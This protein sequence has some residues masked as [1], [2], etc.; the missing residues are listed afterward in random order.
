MRPRCREGRK[1]SGCPNV[2]RRE[3]L[4]RLDR[5]PELHALLGLVGMAA[6][7]LAQT[8]HAVAQRVA[9]HAEALRRIA[10]AAA[11]LE[12]RRQRLDEPAVLRSR[13]ED[14]VDERLEGCVGEREKEL[15]RS[16]VLI[17]GDRAR[18]C[19]ERGA[20]LQEAPAERAAE[21]R[22]AD[23]DAG[24]RLGLDDLVRER[25]HLLLAAGLDEEGGAVA[26]CGGEVADGPAVALLRHL[27]PQ[28]LA[29]KAVARDGG[30]CGGLALRL[31]SEGGHAPPRLTVVE[32]ALLE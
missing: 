30:G 29:G 17:R 1:S 8:V 19:V 13:A 27:L 22:A 14:A 12:E 16:K 9:V 7:L 24:V 10:P 25:E 15:E 28:P 32:A 21:R 26:A 2:T 6:G 20:R 3:R 5:E 18:D 23:A 11:A 4:A 31:R